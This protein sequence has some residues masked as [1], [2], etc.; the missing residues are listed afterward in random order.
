MKTVKNNRNVSGWNLEKGYKSPRDKSNYP[1]QNNG[2]V[3]TFWHMASPTDFDHHC[4][5][6]GQGL[7]IVLSMPGEMARMSQNYFRTSTSNLHNIIISPEL[8]TTTD[9]LRHFTPTQRKCFY[10]D[11]RRL[12]FFKIYTRVNCEFECLAIFTK[13]MCECVKFSMPS[14][15]TNWL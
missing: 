4:S 5:G 15:R 13:T 14:M 1:F 2:D 6:I 12:R 9:R 10:A 11:E 8:I 7:K 3:F